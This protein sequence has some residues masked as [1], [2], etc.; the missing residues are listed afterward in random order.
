MSS[1]YEGR[2]NSLKK[3]HNH[4]ELHTY[5][6]FICI[7]PQSHGIILKHMLEGALDGIHFHLGYDHLLNLFSFYLNFLHKYKPS[8][9]YKEQ[10]DFSHWETELQ[11]W[12][13]VA[14]FL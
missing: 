4:R 14:A 2:E 11:T 13:Q 7:P 8:T 5:R 6:H 1:L 12:E 3:P 9:Y 10:S